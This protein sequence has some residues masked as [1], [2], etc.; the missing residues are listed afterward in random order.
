MM[1]ALEPDWTPDGFDGYTR[2]EETIFDWVVEMV[3]EVVAQSPRTWYLPQE[4][5]NDCT[6]TM[7]D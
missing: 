6:S 5:A 7:G 4:A 1:R 2:D 3:G